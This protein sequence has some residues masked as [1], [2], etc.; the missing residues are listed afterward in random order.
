MTDNLPG[1]IRN[2]KIVGSTIKLTEA[3]H[4]HIYISFDYGGA[5]QSFISGSIYSGVYDELGN[6]GIDYIREL[7]LT[8]GVTKWDDL[9]D[10][11]CRVRHDDNG[12]YAI[13]NLLRNYWFDPEKFKLGW[14]K[15]VIESRD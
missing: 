8:V 7:M 5:G 14:K 3:G 11:C 10:Q 13:G 9:K 15:T 6:Y 12:V 2:A 4:I 1:E